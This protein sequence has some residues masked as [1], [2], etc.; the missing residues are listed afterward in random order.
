MRTAR[1]TVLL[2]P[3]RKMEIEQK[4]AT[5]GISTG[6]LVR[7]AVDDYNQLTPEQEAELAMLVEQANSAIPAMAASLDRMIE[8]VRSTREHIQLT[9]ASLSART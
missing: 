9:L 3:D 8:T 4:A 5:M 6:E 2:P 7:R 1:L